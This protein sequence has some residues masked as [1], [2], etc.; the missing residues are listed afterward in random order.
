[1]ELIKKLHGIGFRDVEARVYLAALELGEGLASEIAKKARLKRPSVYVILK[2]LIKQGHIS[3]YTRRGTT[4]FVARDPKLIVGSAVER[5]DTARHAL[6]ELLALF[7]TEHIAKPRIHYYD[8]YEGIVTIMEDVIVTGNK[9]IDV[10]SDLELAAKTFGQYYGEYIRRRIEKNIF[11]R[12]VIEDNKTGRAFA[13][14]GEKGKR[15]VR[16][17]PANRYNFNDEIIIYD[18]KVAIIAH[19]DLMGVIIQNKM[20]ADTE[21]S[22]FELSWERAGEL[23]PKRN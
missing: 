19:K 18:D 20:F 3:G 13:E 9:T 23:V 5:A 1:M 8:G 22:I 2:D 10:W 7:K 16:L 14:R 11:V 15:D 12:G 17:V 6:P 4:R 21:R